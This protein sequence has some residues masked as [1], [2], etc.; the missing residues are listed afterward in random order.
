MNFGIFWS[1]E[2]KSILQS[3]R[4]T[5]ALDK[6]TGNDDSYSFFKANKIQVE[7]KCE[8]GRVGNNIQLTT[9][10]IPPAWT[11]IPSIISTCWI[12]DTHAIYVG[13]FWKC[14]QFFIYSHS[15]FFGFDQGAVT[16][17][18]SSEKFIR[19]VMMVKKGKEFR[20]KRKS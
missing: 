12:D 6:S 15:F 8:R 14:V 18:F 19:R 1:I 3:I 17:T 10:H 5:R 16:S 13:Q 11:L 4:F 9:F 20:K 7:M 2:C